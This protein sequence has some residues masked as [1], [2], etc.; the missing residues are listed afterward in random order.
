METKRLADLHDG[1]GPEVDRPTVDEIGSSTNHGRSPNQGGSST[2]GR[3]LIAAKRPTPTATG[4]GRCEARAF[5][6]PVAQTAV[7]T[8]VQF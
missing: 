1:T 4:A 3:E 5:L 2:Q 6:W 7:R 8:L